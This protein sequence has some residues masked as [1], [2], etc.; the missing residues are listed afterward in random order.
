MD[1]MM[2]KG[3]EAAAPKVLAE[4]I[5]IQAAETLRDVVAKKASADKEV[6]WASVE[7]LKINIIIKR[8]ECSP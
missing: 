7:R 4:D 5:D 1:K 6:A 3:R 8:E 2:P